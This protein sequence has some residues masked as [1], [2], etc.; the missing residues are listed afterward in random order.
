MLGVTFYEQSGLILP[1]QRGTCSEM[2]IVAVGRPCD[3]MTSYSC[4]WHQEERCDIHT[5]W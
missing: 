4:R 1:I 5:L 3:R 2:L